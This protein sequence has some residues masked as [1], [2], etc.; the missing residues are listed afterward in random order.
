MWGGRFLGLRAYVIWDGRHLS[1]GYQ[2]AGG[3]IETAALAVDDLRHNPRNNIGFRVSGLGFRV[4]HL[5]LDSLEKKPR[6]LQTL[7]PN[8]PP[9]VPKALKLKPINPQ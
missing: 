6:N 2:V 4:N 3:R 7:N 9:K 8:K 1:V 5:C